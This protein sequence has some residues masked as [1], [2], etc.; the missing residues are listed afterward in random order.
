MEVGPTDG[1][2]AVDMGPVITPEH[3]ARVTGYLE[4]ASEEGAEIA[5]DG[6]THALPPETD[7]SSVR[8]SWIMSVPA[9]RVA[10]EEI[11]GPVL[12]VDSRR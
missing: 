8:A 11:F 1:G 5:L 2:T 3:L 4:I 9:M 7:S 10:R 12:S 6:R